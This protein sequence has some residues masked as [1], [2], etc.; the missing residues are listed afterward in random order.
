MKAVNLKWLD[1]NLL[2]LDFVVDPFFP[3]FIR[4]G[5]L[6]CEAITTIGW[7]SFQNPEPTLWATRCEKKLSTVASGPTS[8]KSSQKLNRK[9]F[10]FFGI[11]VGNGRVERIKKIVLFTVF[12]FHSSNNIMYRF[13]G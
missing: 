9:H 3:Y 10:Y 5:K 6:V 11:F 7:A 13:I 2:P 1:G 8:E 12:L 4:L